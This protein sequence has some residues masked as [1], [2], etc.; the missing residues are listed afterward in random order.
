MKSRKGI[1][2][3]G[4]GEIIMTLII[5]FFTIVVTMFVVGM[6][7]LRVNGVAEADNAAFACKNNLMTFFKIN[8]SSSNTTY[9]EFLL[10]SYL[11]GNINPVGAEAAQI[12]NS[13]IG[14]SNNKLWS[15]IIN[16]FLLCASCHNNINSS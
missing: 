13:I 4:F 3:A 5:L 6:I 10:E 12:F 15:S 7:A 14:S 11:K 9:N 8:S 16:K 2:F 1:E